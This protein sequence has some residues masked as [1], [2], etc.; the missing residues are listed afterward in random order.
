M[1]N[2]DEK[3]YDGEGKDGGESKQ[4]FD[5]MP[6]GCQPLADGEYDAIILGTGLTDCIISGECRP[7][8]AS[9]PLACAASVNS[10]CFLVMSPL[11][12]R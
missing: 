8:E 1:S 6:A 9:A 12:F 2:Y 7:I 3:N 4:S 5:W 10:I 11:C